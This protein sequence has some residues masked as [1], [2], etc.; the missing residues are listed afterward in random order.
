MTVVEEEDRKA[1]MRKIPSGREQTITCELV[2][3]EHQSEC[4]SD[5]DRKDLFECL[6]YGSINFDL[7]SKQMEK[8]KTGLVEK[9]VN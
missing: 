4:L 7:R 5:F 2:S 9:C 6:A 1:N 3:N 8:D